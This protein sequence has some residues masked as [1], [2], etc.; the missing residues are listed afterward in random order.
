MQL[1]AHRYLVPSEVLQN[2]Q[3]IYIEQA[4]RTRQMG[5]SGESWVY[6]MK[7]SWRPGKIT[8]GI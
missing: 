5:L 8:Y 3:G 6:H 1:P 4:E 7:L 2:S